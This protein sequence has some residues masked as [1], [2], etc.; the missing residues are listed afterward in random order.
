[1]RALANLF[2]LPTHADASMTAHGFIFL[3]DAPANLLNLRNHPDVSMTV[4]GFTFRWISLL[5]YPIRLLVHTLQ[6][7][8]MAS[9]SMANLF[10]LPNNDSP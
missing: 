7:Q 2:N 6:Q 4:H 5:T 8:S 9:F 10:S 1:M 3:M